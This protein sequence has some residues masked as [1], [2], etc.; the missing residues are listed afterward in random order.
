MGKKAESGKRPRGRPV[1]LTMAE[2][3]SDTPENIARA[4][5][6]SPPKKADDWR[7]LKKAKQRG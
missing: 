5:L 3:I 6:R 4:I 7:Y 1:E 2:R